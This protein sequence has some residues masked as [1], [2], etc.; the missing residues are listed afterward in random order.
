MK[1]LHIT[2]MHGN[3]KIMKETL[4]QDVDIV[5]ISGDLIDK[6]NDIKIV[7]KW[8]KCFKVPVIISSGNHDLEV[9][10]G[11]WLYDLE[12]E[13]IFIHKKIEINCI[14]IDAKPYLSDEFEYDTDILVYHIPPNKTF[15]SIDRKYRDFGD[16]YLRKLLENDFNPKYVFC[17]HI[18]NPMRLK[19]KI[20]KSIIVNSCYRKFNFSI[21][22]C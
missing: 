4:K 20:N 19:D 8:L 7:K 5:T 22:I 9:D 12:K 3:V 15:T 17:G 11:N 2:D 18:H 14:K 1:I 10:E 21:I 13:N 6:K 16:E